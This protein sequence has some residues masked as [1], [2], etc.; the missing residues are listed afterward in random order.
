[1]TAYIIININQIKLDII[2]DGGLIC[3]FFPF[4]FTPQRKINTHSIVTNKEFPDS[5]VSS[6]DLGK[7][8]H[9]I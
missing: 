5:M 3:F 9:N 4:Y 8:K 7:I 2:K 6:K 1:M